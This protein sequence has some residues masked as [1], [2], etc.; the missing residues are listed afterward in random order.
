MPDDQRLNQDPSENARSSQSGILP[1]VCASQDYLHLLTRI[2]DPAADDISLEVKPQ[3]D[4]IVDHLLRQPPEIRQLVLIRLETTDLLSLRATS[5]S[6]HA[7]V[8]DSERAICLDL[9]E[10]ICK[11]Y[12]LS[13]LA[14]SVDNLSEFVKVTRRYSAIR[15]VSDI[16]ASRVCNSMK[17]RQSSTR[18]G[19]LKDVRLNAH[20][21]LKQKLIRSFIILQHYLNSVFKILLENEEHL[22]GLDDEIYSGLFNIFDFDQQQ[23]LTDHMSQLTESDFIDV[24]ASWHAFRSVC[25]ARN[26]SLSSR[27]FNFCSVTFKHVLF[28]DGFAP[29]ASLLDQDATRN[30]QQ[31]V[32]K[33]YDE[34]RLKR[35]SEKSEIPLSSIHHLDTRKDILL[36]DS[37]CRRSSDSRVAYINH[38]DIWDRAAGSSMM[39]KLQRFPTIKTPSEWVKDLVRTIENGSEVVIGDWTVA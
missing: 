34:R 32:L 21:L 9:S 12:C 14:I 17:L 39:Q 28:Y 33:I 25:K 30:A 7:L 27:I 5:H 15:G 8:H 13:H 22:I 38:Q 11:T 6:L 10:H 20:I 4:R 2:P 31:A 29:F 19:A 23:F 35:S 1:E 36:M 16:I 24:T 37:H 26:V 3:Y 18:E